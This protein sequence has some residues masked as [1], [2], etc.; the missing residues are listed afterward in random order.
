MSNDRDGGS[1]IDDGSGIVDRIARLFA[2]QGSQAYLGEPVS[3]SEHM[4]QSA[5]VAELEGAAPA[6]VV[7]A[8]LH[9]LGHL[10]HGMADDAADHG[11]DTV[12]EEAGAR[13]LAPHF[14]PEVTE[15]IR[16]HVAAKRYLCAT[17]PAYLEVLSP[18]S[19]HS[20]QLQGG[21]YSTEE[22]ALY[23]ATPFALDAVAVR[24]W[25]DTGKLPGQMVPGF[26]HFRP[27]LDAC[28]CPSTRLA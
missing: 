20:L 13:W 12:H 15:P 6:L 27:A 14:G 16:L 9:D 18:A 28:R 8:L 19:I 11:I 10:V 23:A 22:A 1:D 5:H 25:D 17:D 7:A 3:I 4:L 21:P 26:E 24:R 2:E